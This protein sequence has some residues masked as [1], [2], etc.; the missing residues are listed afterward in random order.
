[1]S[2]RHVESGQRRRQNGYASAP[3]FASLRGLNG[4][5]VALKAALQSDPCARE[6]LFFLLALSQRDGGLK[7]IA[8][9]LVA[10]FPERIGTPAMHR[11]GCKPGRKLTAKEFETIDAEI[12]PE[13]SVATMEEFLADDERGARRQVRNPDVQPSRDAAESFCSKC[14]ERAERLDEFLEELCCNPKIQV[15]ARDPKDDWQKNYTRAVTEATGDDDRSG[16]KVASVIYFQDVLGA[17]YEFQ[18]RYAERVNADFVETSI[19]KTVFE[20]LDYALET[21]RSALIEGNSGFGKTTGLKAW[22]ESHLGQARYIQL[23]GITTRTQFFRKLAKALGVANGGGMTSGRVQSRVEDFLQRTKLMLVIDEGQYLW[24]QG[25]RIESHPELINWLNTACYNEGVPFAISAT[26]QFS[27][28]RQHVEQSTDWSSEQSRRRTR[29]VFRLPELP[30]K[31]DLKA[32]ALKLVGDLGEAC[33]DY[34]VGYALTSKGYF[35]ALTDAVDDARMSAKKAG[36]DRITFKDLKAVIHDW[37]APSDALLQRVFDSKP[38]KSRRGPLPR[39]AA[40]PGDDSAAPED[41]AEQ[42]TF[43]APARPLQVSGNRLETP[44]RSVRPEAEPALTG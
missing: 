37:R 30:T 29:R 43:R 27:L 39:L 5:A 33:A 41:S 31:E 1:V 4:N 25:K 15:A 9:E 40:S 22:C 6:L 32:V 7:R 34:V 23:T 12:F 19:G 14:R 17:L 21:G 10:M 13:N 11:L 38:E 35:Q 26:S 3:E 20:A 44:P 18:R 8:R 42:G 16:F 28:R 2:T 36:R 24:P